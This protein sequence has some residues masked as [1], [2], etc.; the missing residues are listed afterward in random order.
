VLPIGTLGG[1]ETLTLNVAIELKA[2]GHD[3]RIALLK[4]GGGLA[5]VSHE[6][7]L[8][9]ET[10]GVESGISPANAT[11]LAHILRAAQP[12]AVVCV[13]F[14]ATLWGRLAAVLAHVP[15][16]I[17]AEHSTATL[18]VREGS[19]APLANRLLSGW[20]DAIIAVDQSQSTW[21]ATQGNPVSRIRVIANGIAIGAFADIAPLPDGD[22]GC[23]TVGIVA[24][25][26]PAKNHKRFIRA[27]RRV[28]D[29][30]PAARFLVV[31][32]GPLLTEIRAYAA[33]QGLADS[34]E[35][36]GRVDDVA[37]QLA[38]M[39]VVCLTSDTEAVPL[40]LM[41]AQAAG[42]P[43]VA[44]DV[45]GVAGIVSD[46]VTGF[47]V[48]PEDENAL[49]E[50]IVRLAASPE[51]RIRLGANARERALDEFDIRRTAREYEELLRT[52][53]ESKTKGKG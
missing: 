16:I 19:T 18:A 20:T 49:A 51:L 52:L 50:A 36:A 39:D 3:V 21:L 23:V 43:V 13:N 8:R 46:G 41:E 25:T 29:R 35:F 32:D 48:P 15:V 34:V 22:D 9:C 14:N 6:A 28:S 10:V 47:V 42:R 2:L 37:A 30:I 12:D 1:A 27:A 11:R 17:T 53:I 5:A 24:S 7:G 4:S 45:G 44:T 33:E 31:G 38:R 26:L 40:S